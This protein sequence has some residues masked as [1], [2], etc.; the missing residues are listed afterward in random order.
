[1]ES[2]KRSMFDWDIDDIDL[3]IAHIEE[4]KVSLYKTTHRNILLIKN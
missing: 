4:N 3:I 1:M 2:G